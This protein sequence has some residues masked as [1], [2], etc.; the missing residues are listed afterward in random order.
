MN[1][2]VSKVSIKLKKLLYKQ[3]QTPKP[4]NRD[5]KAKVTHLCYVAAAIIWMH[6]CTKYGGCSCHSL[7]DTD[8]NIELNAIVNIA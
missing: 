4:V 1:S 2:L 8:S 5:M 7:C 6:I 3:W